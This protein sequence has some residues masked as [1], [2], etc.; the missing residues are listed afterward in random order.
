MTTD[1]ID[2]VAQP[3]SYQA[4]L[5]ALVGDDDPAAIQAA[6]P[7]ELRALIDDAGAELRTRPAPNEWS[8]LELVGHIVDAELVVGT[9]YR[10]I[11]AHEEPPIQPYDQ[12]LWADR[13]HHNDAE[14]EELIAPFEALRAANLA[15]WRRTTPDE[16]ARIGMHQER[17]PESYDLTFRML[18]GHDRFHIDQARNTLDQV[19]AAHQESR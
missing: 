18:A 1:F 12:D 11:L 2:P 6:T 9:R 15:L 14:P 8:V 5:L 13:L 4:M 3:S 17:G 10:F 16:H 19:R 7:T